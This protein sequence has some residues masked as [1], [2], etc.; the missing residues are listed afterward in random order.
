MAGD[1]GVDAEG[2]EV[3]RED[4]KEGKQLGRGRLASDQM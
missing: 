1:R 3:K 4:A 2:A